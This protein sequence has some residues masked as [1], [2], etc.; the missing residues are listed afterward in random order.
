MEQ[1]TLSVVLENATNLGASVILNEYL[2][3]IDEAEPTDKPRLLEHI[4]ALM[5]TQPITYEA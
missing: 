1:P 3:E 4:A 2:K 5:L